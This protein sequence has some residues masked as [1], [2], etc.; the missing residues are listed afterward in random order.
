MFHLAAFHLQLSLPPAQTIFSQFLVTSGSLCQQRITMI[1]TNDHHH[2]N[3]LPSLC[4]AGIALGGIPSGSGSRLGLPG[5]TGE[6]SNPTLEEKGLN[7]EFDCQK[8]RLAISNHP[9]SSNQYNQPKII[10]QKFIHPGSPLFLE[11]WWCPTRLLRSTSSSSPTGRA[12]L[13]CPWP[14]VD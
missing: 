8:S 1:S 5:S 2:D 3:D 13:R 12:L 4:S 10:H 7:Y 9:N 14:D 6:K 11:S